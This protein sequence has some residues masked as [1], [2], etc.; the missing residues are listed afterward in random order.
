MR[1]SG[2]STEIVLVLGAWK[3]GGGAWKVGGGDLYAV[4]YMNQ[5]CVF[6]VVDRQCT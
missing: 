2:G 3:V 1:K 5:L 4:K 6:P